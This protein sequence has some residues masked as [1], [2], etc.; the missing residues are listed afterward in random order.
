M[1]Q[2]LPVDRIKWRESVLLILKYLI[3]IFD[4]DYILDIC[5]S[6]STS[7]SKN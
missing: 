1:S 2:N 4:E 5:I 7:E 3:K 6:F